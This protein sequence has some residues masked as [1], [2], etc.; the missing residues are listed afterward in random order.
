MEYILDQS[1]VDYSSVDD[2]SI[3][4]DK[5]IQDASNE[6]VINPDVSSITSLKTQESDK[7]PAAQLKNQ[8]SMT[9][10]LQE[11]CVTIKEKL[12]EVS[13]NSD[14]NKP[15]QNFHLRIQC[16]IGSGGH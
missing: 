3:Q 16:L 2:S 13:Q 10:N 4:P 12:N 11:A 15:C 14:P 7:K 8:K 1:S 9:E 5:E 6:K